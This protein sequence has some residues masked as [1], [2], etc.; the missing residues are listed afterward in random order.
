ME[1]FPKRASY[2]FGIGRKNLVGK[3]VIVYPYPFL[4]FESGTEVEFSIG[5]FVIPNG[6][7][8]PLILRLSSSDIDDENHTKCLYLYDDNRYYSFT[9]L[10]D[11]IYL[12]RFLDIPKMTKR[13]KAREYKAGIIG[14]RTSLMEASKLVGRSYLTLYSRVKKGKLKAEKFFGKYYLE[15]KEVEELIRKEKNK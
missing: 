5:F 12:Q 15:R 9:Q 11:T 2:P 7:K 4:G 1:V 14:D 6:G 8:G 10:Q 13:K 3:L